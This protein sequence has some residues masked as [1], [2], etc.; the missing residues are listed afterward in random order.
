VY[1]LQRKEESKFVYENNHN[2]GNYYY[3]VHSCRAQAV[4]STLHGSVWLFSLFISKIRG[5]DNHHLKALKAVVSLLLGA[6]SKVLSLRDDNRDRSKAYT[7]EVNKAF[8]K[9]RDPFKGWVRDKL[10]GADFGGYVYFNQEGRVKDELKVV[11]NIFI[12]VIT[13]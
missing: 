5:T 4:V 13:L 10:S 9:I 8:G 2:I 3:Y 1:Y 7:D 6:T 12:G 11:A